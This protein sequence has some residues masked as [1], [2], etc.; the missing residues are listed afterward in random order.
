MDHNMDLLKIN[1]HKKTEEFLECNLDNGLIPQITKP[2]RLTQTSTTLIDNIMI[3]T[4]YCGHTNSSILV[5]NISDHMISMTK[6]RK[7]NH[8]KKD[9]VKIS[10][11][12]TRKRNLD[13]LKKALGEVNWDSELRPYKLNIDVMMTRFHRILTDN[14]NNFIP[15]RER[16]VN[17][18][19]IRKE[20]WLTGGLLVSINKEKKLYHKSLK[21]NTNEADIQRYKKFNMVLRKVKRYAKKSYYIDQCIEFKS[22][23]KRL[24]KT[25]KR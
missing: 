25:I 9:G 15:Y 7:F 14:I 1:T 20:C 12:D 23:I 11:R 19:K 13:H 16:L 18:K 24:W 4:K 17:H 3:S 21:P 2:K 8:R 10:S 5:D 6:I 22:N